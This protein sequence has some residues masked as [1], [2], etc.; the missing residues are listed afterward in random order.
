VRIQGVVLADPL[1][2]LRVCLTGETRPSGG[3][4]VPLVSGLTPRGAK[5]TVS[6][7]GDV[8]ADSGFEEN[9]G[10]PGFG[11]LSGTNE[12]CGGTGNVLE[13]ETGIPF[14]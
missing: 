9:I 6:A 5:N 13:F 2:E 14:N 4:A 8:F 1:D 12:F 7:G 3:F 11:I 10:L